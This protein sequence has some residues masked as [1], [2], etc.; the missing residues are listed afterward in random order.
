[1]L[2]YE[3]EDNEKFFKLYRPLTGKEKPNANENPNNDLEHKIF[4]I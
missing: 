4:I 3:D 1:M 2:L